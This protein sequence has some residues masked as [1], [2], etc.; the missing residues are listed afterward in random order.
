[1]GRGEVIFPALFLRRD[2]LFE[3]TTKLFH[4]VFHW[5]AGAIRQSANCCA[6][7]DADAITDFSEQ[8]QILD[9]ALAAADPFGNLEHPAGALPAR[10]AL[11]TRLM[12]IKAGRVV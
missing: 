9:S 3:L 12:G 10:R 7:H 5:P 11:A 6:W 2:E 8:I 4:G 1:M